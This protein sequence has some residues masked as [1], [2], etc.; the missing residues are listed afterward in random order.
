MSPEELVRSV[1][2]EREAYLA[3][4][5]RRVASPAD[6]EDLLQQ[7]LVRAATRVQLLQDPARHRAWF[8]QILRRA[9][10]DHHA[11]RERTEEELCEGTE[12]ATA[13]EPSV[14]GCSLEQLERLRPEY[15]E[16]LR[17]VDL[18]EDSL[19]EVAADL[20]LTVNNTTVRL[21]R[22]RKALRE[23]LATTCGTTS[24]RACADCACEAP[25]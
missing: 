3:F 5:R 4:L 10:A 15:A 21:H 6:A 17:R 7:A 8:F 12:P 23:R 16:M 9:V 13:A 22:A 1:T 19:A 25:R 24:A 14:C 2:G 20:G 11:R 18:E